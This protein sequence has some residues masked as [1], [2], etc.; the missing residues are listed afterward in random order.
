MMRLF[1]RAELRE[2]PAVR[3]ARSIRRSKEA[4]AT[5]ANVGSQTT[6]SNSESVAAAAD[7]RQEIA[8]QLFSRLNVSDAI[9]DICQ[10]G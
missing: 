10:S 8:A 5:C 7:R 2:R 3:I 6:T 1:G 9:H 4:A